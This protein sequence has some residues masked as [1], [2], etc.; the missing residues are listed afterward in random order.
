MSIILSN[1]V[2]NT[3]NT[4]NIT[5][6]NDANKGS[7]NN[8]TFGSIFSAIDTGNLYQSDGASWVNLSG[9]GG[10]TNP[11]QFFIPVNDLSTFID[12]NIFNDVN[13]VLYTQTTLLSVEGIYLDFGSRLYKF[14]DFDPTNANGTNLQVDATNNTIATYFQGSVKGL[15]IDNTQDQYSLANSFNQSGL[16]LDCPGGSGNGLK[17]Y[18]NSRLQG[19]NFSYNANQYHIGDNWQQSIQLQM[20]YNSK[21][22]VTYYDG[23]K[24]GLNFDYTLNRFNI[25]DFD[26]IVNATS[27]QIDDNSQYINFGSASNFF[28]INL[29]SSVAKLLF[30]ADF[31]TTTAGSNSTMHLKINIAGTDYVIPLKNP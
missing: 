22:I 2:I 10:G 3:G 21:E 5:T 14:G 25:G 19:L 7:A 29:A 23:N 24:S 26:G 16:V 13:V 8:Y 17:T 18:N 11:T 27:M 9:G 15:G 31:G 4:P 28:S 6:G 1:S 30:S 12:S 20:S